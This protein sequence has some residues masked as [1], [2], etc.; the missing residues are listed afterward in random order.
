MTNL[1]EEVIREIIADLQEAIERKDEVT[2]LLLLEL[3]ER[4]VK[5]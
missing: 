1:E 2:T 4:M 3:L 5:D